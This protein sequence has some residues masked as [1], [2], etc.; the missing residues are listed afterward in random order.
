MA[1]S[2]FR[3]AAASSRRAHIRLGDD[4]HQRDAGAV[5][6]DIGAVGMLVVQ[7]FA[8]VLLQMQPLD[9]DPDGSRRP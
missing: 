3:N 6:I 8:R 2:F 9:A 4:L 5:E 1:R 7:A